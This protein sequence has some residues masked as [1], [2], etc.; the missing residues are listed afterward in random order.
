MRPLLSL[1]LPVL[2]AITVNSRGAEWDQFRGAAADGKTGADLPLEFGEKNKVAWRAPLPGKAW[3]SPVIWGK[4]IWV[5]NALPDGHKL[6]ALCFDLDTGKK[7]HDI[8]VFL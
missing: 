5:T 4:Q 7:I 2:L 1:F 3:S 6:W 8:L